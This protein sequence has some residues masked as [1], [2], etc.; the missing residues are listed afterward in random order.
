MKEIY[1]IKRISPDGSSEKVFLIELVT[2][3]LRKINKIVVNL[4]LSNL[5]IYI[6]LIYTVYFTQYIFKI[7]CNQG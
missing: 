2:K 4:N 6:V 1:K 5:I 3:L 7:V